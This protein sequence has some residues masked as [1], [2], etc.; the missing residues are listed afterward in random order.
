[1]IVPRM[2]YSCA[3]CSARYQEDG[4]ESVL[5]VD[6]DIADMKAQLAKLQR[7]T[8]RDNIVAWFSFAAAI[9]GLALGLLA[10]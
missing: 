3:A 4:R 2:W 10:R 8:R 7:D 6:C 9:T 5:C 1:M